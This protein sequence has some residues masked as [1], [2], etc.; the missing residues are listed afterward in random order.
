MKVEAICIFL[1]LIFPLIPVGAE[2]TIVLELP[3]ARTAIDEE[4]WMV[5]NILVTEYVM[6]D[7]THVI[8]ARTTD[9]K[10]R[11]DFHSD[12]ELEAFIDEAWRSKDCDRL[13]EALD[14][15]KDGYWWQM[16]DRQYASKGEDHGSWI[17]GRL[18]ECPGTYEILTE[19][20]TFAIGEDALRSLAGELYDFRRY[21]ANIDPSRLQEGIDFLGSLWEMEWASERAKEASEEDFKYTVEKLEEM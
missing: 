19:Y 10:M 13:A 1:M 3:I 4:T 6:A 15:I 9:E 12:Q 11:R 17:L 20:L 5:G 2:E 14:A 18:S 7:G 21:V 16:T 8:E